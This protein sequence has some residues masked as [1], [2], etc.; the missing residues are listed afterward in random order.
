MEYALLGGER[1]TPQPGLVAQ[2]PICGASVTAKCGEV[3][4]WHWAH[5]GGKHCDLWHENETEWH[6]SWKHQFPA[7]WRETMVQSVD[8][9]RHVA[10]IKTETGLVVEFQHSHLSTVERREREAFYDNLIWVVDGTRLK[11][12]LDFLG[13]IRLH[14]SSGPRPDVF[15]FNWRVPQITRRWDESAKLVFLDFHDDHV[16]CVPPITNVWRKYATK[17]PKDEFVS[18]LLA[19]SLPTSI[20]RYE[21][22]ES[23][24]KP[25]LAPAWYGARKTLTWR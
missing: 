19:A 8:G 10:D 17:V 11:R 6:R 18:A 1:T 23:V 12:D 24:P 13:H 2:C 14:E 4:I 22:V 5:K 3:R 9:T 15:P 20:F 25:G 16:W 21:H 7:A